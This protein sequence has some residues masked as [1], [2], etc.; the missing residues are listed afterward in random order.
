MNGMICTEMDG[1][2]VKLYRGAG[3]RLPVVYAN[4]YAE[5]GEAVRKR[6]VELGC[7]PFHLVTV[8]KV[9]WDRNLSPWPSEPVVAKN[10]QFQGNAPD[11]L[12]WF[13]ENVIP[14][15]EEKLEL[16]N[17]VSYIA[18]YSMAGLFALWSLYKTDFF[19]GAVC[20]SGSLWYP[21]F[22]NFACSHS[23]RRIPAGIYLSLGDRESA[24]KNPALQKTETVFRT[25]NGHYLDSGIP[26]VFEMNPGNHYRDMELRMAKG[27][28]WILSR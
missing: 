12:Q 2:T 3:D 28:R 19:S 25:L 6:C 15:A 16:R 1:K 23:F 18:G 11:Y 21:G 24:V 17:P 26:S 10:D 7:P 4:D 5:S 14:Y 13:L 27:Y 20:A 8:S 9:G 22:C